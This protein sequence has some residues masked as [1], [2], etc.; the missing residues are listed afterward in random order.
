MQSP[1][2]I[3]RNQKKITAHLGKRGNVISW[4]MVRIPPA[5]FGDQAPY[6]V[7]L[8][9]LVSGETIMAQMVDL[10]AGRQVGMEELIGMKVITTIRRVTQPDADGII[11]YGIKVKPV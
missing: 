8:V 3:W 4:T 7:V 11:P 2:K 10:P 9:S 1:V 5:G 6:P